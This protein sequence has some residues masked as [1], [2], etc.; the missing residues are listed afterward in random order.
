[1]EKLVKNIL[2]LISFTLVASST[3]A[4][5][6]NMYGEVS[7]GLVSTKDNATTKLGTWKPTLSRFVLG[8]VVSDNLAVE[9]FV[10]Q[11]MSK[12]TVTKSS[13]NYQLSLE[14]SYGLALRPFYKVNNDFEVFGRVGSYVNESKLKYSTTT[15][16]NTYYNALY[17]VGTG[18]KINDKMSVVVDYTKLSNKG[19]LI[20]SQTAI[21]LRYSF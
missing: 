9:G 20:S 16:S 7:Y 1:M 15:K 11:G 14:T 10:T 13:V 8:N 6:S 5:S 17:A 19:N 2:A 4:Q 21:G 18:Y 3:F 12:S